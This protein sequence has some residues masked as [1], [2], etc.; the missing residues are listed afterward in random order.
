MEET[1]LT[2]RVPRKTLAGA[3]QYAARNNTTLTRLITGY[4]D[5]LDSLD[6][7]DQALAPE[8]RRLTGI[9]SWKDEGDDYREAY[10]RHLEEKYLGE[11]ARLV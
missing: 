7:K 4:L 3:K 9:A 2:V 1:K 8:V 10:R 5:R 11:D 6:A